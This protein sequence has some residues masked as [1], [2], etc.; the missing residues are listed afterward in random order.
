MAKEFIVLTSTVSIIG[1]ALVK[2]S[3]PSFE[4]A[5][6]FAESLSFEVT[7]YESVARVK[8]KHEINK[9]DENTDDFTRKSI[10]VS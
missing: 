5:V 4:E 8:I 1:S 10:K 6:K 2:K 7:I 9:F 3:F